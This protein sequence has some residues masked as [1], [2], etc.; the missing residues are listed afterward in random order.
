[1]Q[2]SAGAGTA[3][4]LGGELVALAVS[5]TGGLHSLDIRHCYI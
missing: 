2:G 5:V 1:M 3:G 4:D